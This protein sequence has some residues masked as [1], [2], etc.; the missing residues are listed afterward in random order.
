MTSLVI[1]TIAGS[2][3]YLFSELSEL[4]QL[5]FSTIGRNVQSTA[6]FLADRM[7][8]SKERF[9]EL[10]KMSYF[11]T[12]N[13]PEYRLIQSLINSNKTPSNV[14]S[15][16]IMSPLQSQEVIYHVP[17]EKAA[18][19]KVD[20]NTPLD[21]IYLLDVFAD[22]YLDVNHYKDD[23]NRYSFLDEHTQ[24]RLDAK[25]QSYE[26]TV[27]EWGQSITGFMPLYATDGSYLG[28]LG[29]DAA[30]DRYFNFKNKAA[31]GVLIAFSFC[32][33]LLLIE[34][35]YGFTILNRLQGD[36]IYLDALTG[37]YNRRYLNEKL[38]KV[39]KRKGRKAEQLAFALLDID[40]FKQY[41]DDYGHNTGDECLVKFAAAVKSALTSKLSIV[42]RYGG[43]E[44]VA[45]FSANS[46]DEIHGVLKRMQEKIAGISL[47]EATRPVTC[48][49]GCCYCSPA[50]FAKTSME[51]LLKVS[52][53]HLYYV[54]HHG[55]NDYRM[56][57][58]QVEN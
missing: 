43:E 45:C 11:E 14:K 6:F 24:A 39:I 30:T 17:K 4:I 22:K 31:N 25:M 20:E 50:E 19:Y 12:Q 8:I 34:T 55:R 57:K 48:S 47:I 29:V 32:V 10:K 18:F 33:I 36:K 5:Y 58:F 2:V 38:T 42:V 54:K 9:E 46:E 27:D 41:N 3:F 37:V 35:G 49:I 7:E 23:M 13:T 51:K 52:D 1:I 56:S 15:A 28:L 26:Y 21:L 40:H 44:F 53:D 16:Y